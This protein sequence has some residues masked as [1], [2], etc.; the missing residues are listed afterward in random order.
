[1]CSVACLW[2]STAIL[3]RAKKPLNWWRGVQNM[4]VFPIYLIRKLLPISNLLSC[5]N[6]HVF[7]CGWEVFLNAGMM[8]CV[9]GAFETPSCC[10]VGSNLDCTIRC[11]SFH[12]PFVLFCVL[13]LN[14]KLK[15]NCLLERRRKKKSN[16]TS[17]WRWRSLQQHLSW[18]N[19]KTGNAIKICSVTSKPVRK[20]TTW[21]FLPSVFVV[22][23][24]YLCL[25][26]CVHFPSQ[27]T[28]INP[29]QPREDHHGEGQLGG[30]L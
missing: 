29:L 17:W 4:S 8:Q 23:H 25:C 13:Q 11:L 7:Y 21:V 26:V 19:T 12:Y 5:V 9:R 15:Q 18:I 27:V 3:L 16:V 2:R 28:R 1:M 22:P 14:A 24:T 30:E 20:C 10:I 6:T